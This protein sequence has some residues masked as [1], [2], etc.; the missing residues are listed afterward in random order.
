LSPKYGN[1]IYRT[2]VRYYFKEASPLLDANDLNQI[3][4]VMLEAIEPFLTKIYKKQLEHDEK[5]AQIDK[6]FEQIDQR[7]E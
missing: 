3:K 1:I 7:F 4:T 6:K 5:F 2:Y